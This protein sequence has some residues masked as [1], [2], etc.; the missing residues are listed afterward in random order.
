MIEWLINKVKTKQRIEF[1]SSNSLKYIWQASFYPRRDESIWN[2]YYSCVQTLYI[3]RI[4]FV[5]SSKD[6]V[7]TQNLAN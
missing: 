4:K 1:Q 3:S 7:S 2:I 6:F 5:V